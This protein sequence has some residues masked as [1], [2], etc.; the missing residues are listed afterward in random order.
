VAIALC[1]GIGAGVACSSGDDHPGAA[2]GSVPTGTPTSESPTPGSL[3]DG[4]SPDADDAGVDSGPPLPPECQA[5]SLTGAPVTSTNFPEPVPDDTGGT[6]APGTYDLTAIAFY[7]SSNEGDPPSAP[8]IHDQ[9]SMEVTDELVRIVRGDGTSTTISA[10]SWQID[11]AELVRT[12][13]C[14]PLAGDQTMTPFT[15]TATTVTLHTAQRR[16][17]IF[18]KRP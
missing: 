17:D 10:A 6:I 12:E 9:A 5:L 1:A 7:P 2:G 14:P 15:A 13:I 4:G 8:P 11:G 3:P 16:W 18:T